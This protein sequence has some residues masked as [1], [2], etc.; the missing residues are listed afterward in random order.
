MKLLI[1]TSLIIVLSALAQLV[2][3]WWT[4]AIVAFVVEIFYEEL[5]L[6]SFLTGFNAVFL[7]WFGYALYIDRETHALLSSKVVLLFPI[8]ETHWL[9]LIITGLVG[10]LAG[11]MGALTGQY[12]RRWWK[13]RRAVAVN[14]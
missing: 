13:M 10:G 11:G 4:I 3:P 12:C 5:P 14:N 9:L 2:L 1:K 6:A 7:L 8:P